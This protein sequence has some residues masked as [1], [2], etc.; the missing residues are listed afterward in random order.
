MMRQCVPD[1][2]LATLTR[3]GATFL[4]HLPEDWPEPVQFKQ[5]GSLLLG[6]GA[7]WS[8]LQQDAEI[9]RRLGIDV[10][11]WT[12]DQVKQHVPVLK[13]AE[14]EGAVWCAQRRHRRYPCAAFGVFKGSGQ[15]RGARP[16]RLPG[17]RHSCEK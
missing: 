2:D 7:G 3:D 14:F 6:S 1:P 11:L 13:Q 5:N 8:K 10:V 15:Q 4:R 9:G 17:A 12:P 16:I